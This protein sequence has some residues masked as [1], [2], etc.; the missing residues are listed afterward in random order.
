MRGCGGIRQ[1]GGYQGYNRLTRPSRKGGDPVHVAHC[2][3]HSRRKLKEG[4]DRNGPEIAAEGDAGSPNSTRPRPP[5]A[6]WHRDGRRAPAA[7]GQGRYRPHPDTRPARRR[8]R[9]DGASARDVRKK[10]KG[11]FGKADRVKEPHRDVI[12]ATGPVNNHVDMPHAVPSL[13]IPRSRL[14]A[15]PRAVRTVEASAAPGVRVQLG[16]SVIDA[17]LGDRAKNQECMMAAIL[18]PYRY[19]GRSVEL[20][21]LTCLLAVAEELHVGRAAAR[22]DIAQPPLSRQIAALEV[23]IGA[24]LSDRSR[25]QIR[26][27]QAGEV[28]ERQRGCW[29]IVWMLPTR[30]PASLAK[31]ARD[32][33]VSL[34]SALHPM[35]SCPT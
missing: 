1:R 20:R 4:L 35:V 23:D 21:R 19:R 15:Q 14:D 26:L 34:L 16:A 13:A 33:C 11:M 10:S 31:V 24:Q 6:A 5:V 9:H 32:D 29:W 8:R 18:I 30:K 25:S 7:N 2:R 17:C 12:G 3:P 28:P 27:T 22:L